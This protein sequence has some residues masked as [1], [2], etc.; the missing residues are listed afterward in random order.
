MDIIGYEDVKGMRWK[1]EST[2]KQKSSLESCRCL[3]PHEDSNLSPSFQ[4]FLGPSFTWILLP[5]YAEL[6]PK[7]T[8]ARIHLNFQLLPVLCWED[9]HQKAITIL[10]PLF[11]SKK[12]ENI[13]QTC[14]NTQTH[15]EMQFVQYHCL[16]FCLFSWKA[17]KYVT[18]AHTKT[19]NYNYVCF[20]S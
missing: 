11:V 10:I 2:H 6:L 14:T 8:N 1:I 19:Y 15:N 13:A 12:F 18:A 9:H 4:F 16:S 17:Q 20:T 7:A 5:S 3:A